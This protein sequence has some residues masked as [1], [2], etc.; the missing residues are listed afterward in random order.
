MVSH[1]PPSLESC[2]SKA[3]HGICS[4]VGASPGHIE[5]WQDRSWWQRG[6]LRISEQRGNAKATQVEWKATRHIASGSKQHIPEPWDLSLVLCFV[7]SS[8]R[9]SRETDSGPQD[10]E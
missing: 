2:T 8:P 4:D 3:F 10:Q 5:P 7:S 9:A 1:V 6:F